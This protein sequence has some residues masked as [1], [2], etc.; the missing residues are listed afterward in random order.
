MKSHALLR[1]ITHWTFSRGSGSGA[2]KGTKGIKEDL[3]AL[4]ETTGA[5]LAPRPTRAW[6]API[7]EFKGTK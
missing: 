1:N 6:R 7:M 4:K 3:R 2:A 5:L